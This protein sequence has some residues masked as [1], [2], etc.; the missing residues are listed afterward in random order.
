MTS[1]RKPVSIEG[2]PPQH[3]IAPF[4]IQDAEALTE[5]TQ[6]LLWKVST[7]DHGVAVL[8][9]YKRGHMG[10][11]ASGFEF[12]RAVDGHSA[13]KVFAETKD[14]A[15]IEYLPGPSLGDL[16]RGEKDQEAAAQLV[17]VANALQS[18]TP[19]APKTVQTITQW[20]TAL[21]DI[22]YATLLS[23]KDR[24]NFDRAKSV[25]K[26][27]LDTSQDIC[28]L[29]GDLHHD[30]IRE[31]ERGFCAFDAKGVV[32]E[33]TYELANAFRN[34]KGADQLIRDPSRI[35]FLRDLWSTEFAVSKSRLMHWTCVKVALSICWRAGDVVA[36]DKELDLLE[37]F[38]GILDETS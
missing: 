11:E 14:A 32:G 31:T 12:L 15:L 25:A 2:L 4:G 9:F 29:H 7:A 6:A 21:F 18:V 13:A 20:L 30:N 34:P 33:R 10:N 3:L 24:A 16:T 35:R 36:E 8:K 27:L 17:T 26:E 22:E 5:T 38:F 37:I 19:T 28:F 1:T 23:T